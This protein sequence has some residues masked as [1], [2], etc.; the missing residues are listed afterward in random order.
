VTGY[1]VNTLKSDSLFPQRA[2]TYIPTEVRPRT[3][4][5]LLTVC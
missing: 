2:H 4:I 5:A 1:G 3:L